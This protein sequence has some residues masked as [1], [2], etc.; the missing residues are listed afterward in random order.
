M[1]RAVVARATWGL[2]RELLASVPQAAARGVVVGGDARRMSRE[3]AEDVAAILAGAGISVLLFDDP[4]PTPLVGFTVKRMR[5]A[6]RGGHHREPQSARVQRLQG[7]LGERRPDRAP[8]RRAHRGRHRARPL[9]A[10]RAAAAAAAAPRARA[11]HRRA[12]RCGR[13]VP[14]RRGVRWRCTRKPA[15]GTCT[16]STRRSTAWATRSCAARSLPRASRTS[17]ACPSSGS[18]T[19]PSPRS[20]SRTPRSRARWTARWP[21]RGP[22]RR[23]LVL[24]NDPDVGP[25]R[26][27]VPRG[28]RVPAA[29]GQRARSAPRA[30]S[31][32]GE[33]G[34]PSARRPGVDRLVAAARPHRGGPRR[35][36]RRDAD[37]LQ[38]DR[39][40][41]DRPGARGLR[42]RLRIRRGP[43]VLRRE[44]R[45]TTR[46]ASRRRCSRPKSRRSSGSAARPSAARSTRS[47]GAGASSRARR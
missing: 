15:I 33:A 31:P 35:P 2:A 30:L 11:R 25:P 24:A 38:V 18:R 4:V 7:V 10:G 36:L 19:A 37:G 44:R 46:T 29:H 9:R 28:R 14:R 1:N 17:R 8:D 26:H 42:V 21:S 45:V 34:D 39:E 41:R 3:L 22:A 13:R 40:P 5:A 47:P 23:T 43:R 6:A 12:A 16:S 32:D 27:G 20:R